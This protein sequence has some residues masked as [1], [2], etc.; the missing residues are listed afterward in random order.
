MDSR[1]TSSSLWP[2]HG[3]FQQARQPLNSLL[4]ILVPL[5]AYQVFAMKYGTHLLAP[6]DMGK[7]L[8][9]FGA[10]ATLLPP[11]LIL[12]VLVVQ[13]F[14]HRCKWKFQPMVLLKMLGE[15]L[16]WVVPML[17]MSYFTRQPMTATGPTTAMGPSPF[18]RQ[19]L[20][21]L[22]AGIYEEFIFRLVLTGLLLFIL[23]DLLE[24]PRE[25]S[26]V[27]A[28]F[29]QAALFSL[30]HL[31]HEQIAAPPRS[32]GAR[33]SSACWPGRTSAGSTSCEATA[34]PSQ[35]TRSGTFTSP[36]AR[37]PET[38]AISSQ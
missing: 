7:F 20:Q 13:H 2:R 1:S 33:S 3:Y 35:P 21:G 25:I 14:A 22:G 28:I 37:C 26:A 27:V 36:G 17:A 16:V 5:I 31:S 23:A 34:S 15:S 8:S 12:V 38:A 19:A 32:P 10:T 6:Q 30:Y 4:L 24:F 9:Y 18:A 11:A 29:A